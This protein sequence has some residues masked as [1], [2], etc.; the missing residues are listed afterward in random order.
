MTGNEMCEG[1]VASWN[2]VWFAT[3]IS[4][5][6]PTGNHTRVSSFAPSRIGTENA[7][8]MVIRTSSSSPLFLD[9]LQVGAWGLGLSGHGNPLPDDA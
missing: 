2:I 9:P 1:L 6:T 4:V 3:R 7:T 5:F 8:G